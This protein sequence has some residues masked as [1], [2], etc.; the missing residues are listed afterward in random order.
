LGPGAKGRKS[1]ASAKENAER[2]DRIAEEIIVDAYG[3]EER[4]MYVFG[5]EGNSCVEGGYGVLG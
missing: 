5:W 4:A 3:A 1:M 2:E